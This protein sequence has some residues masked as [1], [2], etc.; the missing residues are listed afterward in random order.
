MKI[1]T[2]MEVMRSNQLRKWPVGYPR[3]LKLPVGS[4]KVISVIGSRRA[5]K[6]DCLYQV[7]QQLADQGVPQE[8][9]VFLNFEDE[10]LSLEMQDLDLILQA[11]RQLY[12]SQALSDCYFFF[13]EI[14]NVAG[15]EKF[16]R[17][18]YDNESKHVF[19]TGSNARLLSTEIATALRG[20]TLTYEVYPLSFRELLGFREL[21]IDLYHAQ[22]KAAIV[23]AFADFMESGGFPEVVLEKDNLIRQKILQEYFNVMLF[24]DLVE[25]YHIG[26]VDILRY[27][28]KKVMG[29]VGSTVSVNNIYKDIKS[30]RYEV[31]KNSLYTYFEYIT[32][33]YMIRKLDK[34]DFSEMKQARSDKKC[35]PIDHGLFAALNFHFSKDLGKKLENLVA[36][37]F[38]KMGKTPMYFKQIK[39]CDFVV[40]DGAGGFDAY[41]VAYDMEATQT[42][43]REL[44]GLVAACQ[45]L[46]KNEG[47]VLTFDHYEEVMHKD[48]QVTMKPV[49]RWLLE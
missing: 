42:K 12:P 24:R 32:D 40:E 31:A 36:L 9:M 14:Q 7:M 38:F 23:A 11:Y 29:T 34:F 37:E 46:G 6:S 21:R 3:E 26:Q 20:R 10:R 45:V 22:S 43:A 27:F 25:R 19:V 4:G 13:D 1:D 49:W 33:S 5:G 18:V 17:R 39:E 28:I 15:W 16:V 44:D 47:T 35:Y 30:N 41:Q 8:R 2:L 48:V